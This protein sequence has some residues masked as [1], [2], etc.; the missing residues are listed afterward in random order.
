MTLFAITGGR[1]FDGR[2]WH[3]GKVCRYCLLNALISYA[4]WAP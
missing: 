4:D 3:E 1:I 2:E